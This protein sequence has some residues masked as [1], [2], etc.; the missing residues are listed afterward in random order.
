ML[1]QQYVNLF[2]SRPAASALE[3]CFCL[4]TICR[5]DGSAERLRFLSQRG[6][7]AVLGR[8]ALLPKE[9]LGILFVRLNCFIFDCKARTVAQAPE[10]ASGVS[11]PYASVW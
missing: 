1:K 9:P 10:T 5:P 3:V 4:F 7:L 8:P 11:V 6:R 2:A